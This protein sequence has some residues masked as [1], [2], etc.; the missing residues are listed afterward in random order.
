LLTTIKREL[1]PIGAL[2]EFQTAG[3]F[4]NWWQ[5]IRYDLKTI[6]SS[7]WSP[8]LIPDSYLIGAYFQAEVKAIEELESQHGEAEA[9]LTEAV[10]AVEYEAGEDEEVTAKAV[11]DYLKAQIK[12]L[13]VAAQAEAA[14]ELK[15]MEEQ[16]EGVKKAEDH[17]GELKKELKRRQAE[18][19]RKLRFKR[20]GVEDER[21]KLNKFVLQNERETA[22]VKSEDVNVGADATRAEKKAAKNRE[23]R[24]AALER[25]RETLRQKLADLNAELEATGGVITPDEAK[26]LILKKL[27]DLINNE[28]ARY[29]NTEKRATIAVFEKLWDKYAISARA[30]GAERAATMRELNDYL[31]NLGYLTE[32][33]AMAQV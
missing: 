22:Q 7:G 9:Q 13:K 3:I 24:L 26:R 23:K 4:V 12:E 6:T 17:I 27:Y 8:S 33:L 16:L 10:E 28:L 32:E 11:K 5:T 18:L 15:K 2:D 20:E 1:V 25:D 30:I 21:E 31:R 14:A 29:L 19:A